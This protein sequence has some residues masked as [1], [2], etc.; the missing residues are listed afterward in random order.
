MTS[1]PYCVGVD[2]ILAAYYQALNGV[3]KGK[4]PDDQVI[5][6]KVRGRK[7]IMAPNTLIIVYM[8]ATDYNRKLRLL[9]HWNRTEDMFKD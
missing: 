3:D 5:V 6:K 8:N 1:D 7:A 2:G 4:N 9:L